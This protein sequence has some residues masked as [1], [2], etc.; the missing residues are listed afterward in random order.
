MNLK[1]NQVSQAL[2]AIIFDIKTTNTHYKTVRVHSSS[3]LYNH[4]T[5]AKGLICM[6]VTQH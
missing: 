2:Q 5:M 4:M 6:V 1:K 3:V